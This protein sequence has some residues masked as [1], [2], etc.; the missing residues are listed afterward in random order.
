MKRVRQS[1]Q[2]HLLNIENSEDVPLPKSYSSVSKATTTTSKSF[3]K[4]KFKLDLDYNKG[5]GRSHK[6]EEA[7]KSRSIQHS[8]QKSQDYKSNKQTTEVIDRLF[9]DAK[10]RNEKKGKVAEEA[11]AIKAS[12]EI[13]GVTFKPLLMVPLYDASHI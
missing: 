7:S 10:A 3:G 1:L 4:N 9:E 5:S 2:K 13:E 8:K 12:K 6:I 11:A